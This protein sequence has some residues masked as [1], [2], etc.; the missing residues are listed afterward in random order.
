[1]A[2]SC[3]TDYSKA[4]KFFSTDEE[5]LTDD[6]NS[7]KKH[8]DFIVWV[9]EYSKKIV[10]IVFIFYILASLLSIGVILAIAYINGEVVGIDTLLTEI[11][12]TFRDVIGGYI[13]KS[14]TEN[15]FKIAGNYLIGIYDAKLRLMEMKYNCKS[16]NEEDNIMEEVESGDTTY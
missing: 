13:I 15:S 16:S 3:Y 9:Q 11:N 1:M 5:N 2:K 6:I 12:Q 7:A 10:T 8:K 4:S 14:A